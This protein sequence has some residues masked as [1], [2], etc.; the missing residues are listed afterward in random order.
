MPP[1]QPRQHRT[2]AAATADSSGDQ[3]RNAFYSN[4]LGRDETPEPLAASND[5]KIVNTVQKLITKRA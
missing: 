1:I 5:V 2:D 4:K 3:P